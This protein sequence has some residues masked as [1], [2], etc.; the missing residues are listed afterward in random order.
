MNLFFCTSSASA[1]TRNKLQDNPSATPM[2]T[3][4]KF[5]S[6]FK[7]ET[8]QK[9]WMRKYLA[10]FGLFSIFYCFIILYNSF[11]IFQ[12]YF[13]FYHIIFIQYYF[14]LQDNIFYQVLVFNFEKNFKFIIY[15]F[16]MSLED[17]N[18]SIKGVAVISDV[19]TDTFPYIVISSI[20]VNLW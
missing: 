15:I 14:L 10:F 16:K 12:F 17:I 7:L 5:E 19:Y 1:D 4:R 20:H 2:K 18:F 3:V 8:N 9:D 6:L 11:Y 13:I